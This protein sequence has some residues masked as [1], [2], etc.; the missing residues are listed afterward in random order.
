MLIDQHRGRLPVRRMCELLGVSK[1]AYYRWFYK[2]PPDENRDTQLEN[3]IEEIVIQFSGYGY[4]RVTAELKRRG[5][6]INHKKV[7]FIMRAKHL[8]KKRRRRFRKTTD[9][10]HALPIFPNLIRRFI[11]SGINQLWVADITYIRLRSTFI[12]LAVILDAFSRRVVGWNLRGS[13]DRELSL[14]ALRMALMKREIASGLIHHSDR[15]IQY[16]CHDYIDLLKAYGFLVSMS[17]PGNP[18]DNAKAES[19]MATL[20]K[21]EVNLFDYDNEI[22]AV[23]RIGNFIEDVYNRKRLHSALGYLPPAEFEGK[24][25][26]VELA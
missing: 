26:T 15:G 22:E 19:F 13:L 7:L 3:E 4:R 11:P 16:A 25:L 12:Y 10:N 23:S 6:R 1:T 2:L 9:S 8:I 21:E 18:Y 20:K 5:R 14:S 24:L 17:R